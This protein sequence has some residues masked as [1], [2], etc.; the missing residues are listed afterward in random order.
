[1]PSS[2]CKKCARS[3]EHTSELQSHDNL[4]CRLLLGKKK[5][6]SGLSCLRPSRRRLWRWA[7]LPGGVRL[8]AVRGEADVLHLLLAPLLGDELDFFFIHRAP[9]DIDPF[10]HPGVLQ[11]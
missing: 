4:V 2:A 11:I 5:G 3:E 8:A 9:A 10:P 1:M 6:T 7:F